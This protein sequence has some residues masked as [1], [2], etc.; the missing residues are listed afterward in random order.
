VSLLKSGKV[1]GI[2]FETLARICDAL[3]CAPGELLEFSRD[4][5]DGIG[6]PMRP[7]ITP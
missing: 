6:Q 3:D 7:S 1:R 5:G 2:R 4:E